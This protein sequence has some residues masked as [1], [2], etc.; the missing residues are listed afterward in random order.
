MLVGLKEQIQPDKWKIA[1]HVINLE[2]SIIREIL[3]ISSQPGVISFAG[4]LPAPELFPLE[5]LKELSAQVIDK[6][7]FKCCQYS[8]SMGILELRE[9]VAQRT[10]D[11]GMPTDPDNVL[12]TCGAQQGI[13]LLARVFIEPG[14]YIITENPTYL[15]ALQAF[16]YYRAKYATV[17]MDN[18]GMI[19][20]QVEDKIKKYKPKLIYTVSN[21]QN[22]TGITMS[23][24]RRIE[25]V[26]L[27]TKYNL[28]VIDDNPYG[29][30][31]FAGK[32]VPELK[33][34][35]GDQV[36]TLMTFS[37]IIAPGFRIAWMN[38]HKSI[39][40]QFEKVKQCTDLHTNA[41]SQ[42][43]MYEFVSQGFLEPHIEKIK[44]NYRAKRELML[45]VMEET[46]PE[47]VTWTKPEG[48]LFLWLEFPKNFSAKELLPKAIE[49]K[50][51][52]VYGQPFYP[53]GE[54]ENTMR[55]NF[56]NATLEGIDVGIRRLAELIKEN[57]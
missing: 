25:L 45:K 44:A 36:I 24:E 3:K 16:N 7:G 34:Y 23:E 10:T 14:D 12:V 6:Y 40:K 9:W 37:K 11:K 41:F 52:Y 31:R 26:K 8:L 29:D 18:D 39:T 47:G 42:Y 32:P 55:L 22:P 35:G 21:F 50:V 5:K 30:I 48:G 17:E 2:T 27:A 49:K 19:I 56:S 1:D 53:G 4:G 20:D 13:E 28:P 51:A 57:M 15:G 38:A 43:L 33:S 46:F 54:G